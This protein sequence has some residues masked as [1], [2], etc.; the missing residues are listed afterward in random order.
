MD[1]D[2]RREQQQ[3]DE[4]QAGKRVAEYLAVYLVG[5]MLYQTM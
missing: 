5:M 3:H 2:R 1:S 4:R